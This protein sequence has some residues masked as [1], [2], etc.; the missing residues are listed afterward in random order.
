MRISDWSS[1]VCSSDLASSMCWTGM[2]KPKI[3]TSLFTT[4]VVPKPLNSTTSP[5]AL[6][7]ICTRKQHTH[8]HK[9]VRPEQN[10]RHTRSEERREGKQCV[11]KGRSRWSPNH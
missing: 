8:T 1:D 9:E 7:V 6:P 5:A 2:C 4:D 10:E 3:C 11:S